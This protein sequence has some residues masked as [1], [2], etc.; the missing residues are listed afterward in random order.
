MCVDNVFTILNLKRK[1]GVMQE[2]FTNSFCSDDMDEVTSSRNVYNWATEHTHL[3]RVYVSEHDSRV[4]NELDGKIEQSLNQGKILLD[5]LLEK[6]LSHNKP[7][8]PISGI[9]RFTKQRDLLNSV[10]MLNKTT[11]YP[12]RTELGT[13]TSNK[14]AIPLPSRTYLNKK[15]SSQ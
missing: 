6:N 1:E 3:C 5:S 11:H 8:I 2:N 4:R 12:Y 14:K 15:T 7:L 10:E 9:N 13:S